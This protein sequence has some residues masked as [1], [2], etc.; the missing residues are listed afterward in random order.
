MNTAIQDLTP[1]LVQMVDKPFSAAGNLDSLLPFSY[2][3]RRVL[4]LGFE[5]R[6][7]PSKAQKPRSFMAFY[8]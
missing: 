8:P 4:K 1:I 5:H 2:F 3:L 6:N 7:R